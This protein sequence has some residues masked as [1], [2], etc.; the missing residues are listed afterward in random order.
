MARSRTKFYS[1]NYEKI[2]GKPIRSRPISVDFIRLKKIQLIK[3]KK[4]KLL[5]LKRNK[6]L[7]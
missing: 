1:I 7:L 6:G 5:E 3:A 4:L 2:Y